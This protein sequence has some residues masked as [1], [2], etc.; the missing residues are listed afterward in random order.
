M[1]RLARPGDPPALDPVG[2]EHGTQWDAH[3][4]EDGPLLD[5]E[6][7]VGRRGRELRVC[8]ECSVEVD[9]ARGER[10]GERDPVPVGQLPQLLLVA[11]RPGG[12]RGAEERAAEAGTLLVGPV[13]E[14]HRHGRRALL[15]DSAQY[16]GT[17]DDVEA[18]VEPATVRHRVDV[19]A[20]QDG[21]LGVAAER[22]PVVARLVPLHLEREIREQR[23]E[24]GS[25]G[26]P[27]LGPRHALSPV[28][29]TC[30]LPQLAQLGD[31]TRRFESHARKPIV[32]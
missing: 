17:G 18:A 5:V 25:R 19:A 30:E 1:R 24:P 23:G 8:V 14:P 7:E 26:I 16:L 31:D 4:F 29:V 11:H 12:G 22:P 28:G 15:C 13:D 9:A 10:V 27:G 21:A 6:L 20:D 2:A 32:V 3:C